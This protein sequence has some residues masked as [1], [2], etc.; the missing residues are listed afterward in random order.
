MKTFRQ[1]AAIAILANGLIVPALA[2]PAPDFFGAA[3]CEPPYSTGTATELYEAIE[4]VTKVD[5]SLLGA[6]IYP[7]PFPIE[8]DGFTATAV[9][10]SG[11]AVGVLIDGEAADRLARQYDLAPE[12]SRLLG[13]LKRGFSRELPDGQQEMQELGRISVVARE[14]SALPGKTLLACEFVSNEDRTALDKI[15]QPGSSN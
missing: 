12:S 6:A 11:M 10:F 4:K 3:L 1:L 8:R 9:V 14:G 5:T 2:A 7:L 15:E 13:A